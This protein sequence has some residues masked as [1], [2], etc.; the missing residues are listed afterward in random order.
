MFGGAQDIYLRI[1]EAVSVDGWSIREVPALRDAV[2]E[3]IVDELARLR[4]VA[5]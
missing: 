4:G 1:L 3:R 2:R 5:R